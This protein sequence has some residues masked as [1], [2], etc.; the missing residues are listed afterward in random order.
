M[1]NATA[2]TILPATATAK[3]NVPALAPE[4]QSQDA[5]A[6]SLMVKKAKALAASSLFPDSYRGEQGLANCI[7]ALDIAERIGASPLMVAQN[8][9]IIHGRPSW[10]S[11]FV[12]ATVN[13][14]KRF[15]P[16]RFEWVNV[17]KAGEAPGP[18]WGCRAYAKSKEDGEVC[19]GPT[20]TWG[21]ANREGWVKKTG[22][23]WN[24]MPELMFHY[25]A[26]AFWARIFCPE[27]MLGMN[28]ADEMEDMGPSDGG[29]SNLPPVVT[30]L[31]GHDRPPLTSSNLY[32]DDEAAETVQPEVEGGT[33]PTSPRE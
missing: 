26:A 30:N 15:T 9:D 1:T 21:I 10:R 6:Y 32:K 22:S 20:V 23:K 28:T 19:Y 5:L 24:T 8:L 17:P 33:I 4:S 13:A 16:L 7:I 18:D 29:G 25:R 3:A 11:T 2:Q 12:I 27:L 14:S 31:G